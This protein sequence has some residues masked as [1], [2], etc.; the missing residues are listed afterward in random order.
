MAA[1]GDLSVET[2]RDVYRAGDLVRG[3]VRG[4]AGFDDA[5]GVTVALAHEGTHLGDADPVEVRLDVPRG[6]DAFPFDL[7]LPLDAL[8]SFDGVRF[9]S[10]W[11][12]RASVDLG[13]RVDPKVAQRIRVLPAPERIVDP[14][15]PVVDDLRGTRLFVRGL[16]IFAVVDALVLALLWAGVSDPPT[17][18]MTALA[19]PLI[20]SLG[21][22]ALLRGGGPLDGFAVEV[23]RR[24]WRL[25]E[26]VSVTVRI[27]GEPGELG[28]VEVAL[29]GAEEWTTSSG[30]TSNHHR[31][32]FHEQTRRIGVHELAG[33]RTARR[34][35]RI[36][37]EFELPELAPP[38]VENKVV[39]DAR[40]SIEVPRRHD[41]LVEAPLEVS[42]VVPEASS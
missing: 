22:V 19:A 33:H 6:V 37:L 31:E 15:E 12:V 7:P 29:T 26:V 20:V 39:W 3:T 5:R 13:M 16:A 25:G 1:V 38:T 9:G 14:G 27:E 23:P 42:G 35:W 10:A 40:A 30:S 2:S 11:S 24:R 17:S 4:L 41:P 28:A 18:V 8:P 36:E 32:V 21:L 34:E